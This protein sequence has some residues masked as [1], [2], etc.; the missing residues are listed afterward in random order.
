[1]NFVVAFRDDRGGGECGDNDGGG[2]VPSRSPLFAP[3]QP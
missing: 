3:A 1:M 2:G